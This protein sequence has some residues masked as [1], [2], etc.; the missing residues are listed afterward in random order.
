MKAPHREEIMPGVHLTFLETSKFK[1]S[2]MSAAFVRPLAAHE[3]SKNALLP[4][5]LLRGCREYPDMESL[6]AAMDELYGAGFSDIS[7]KKEESQLVGLAASVIDD[8]YAPGE[9][10]KNRTAKL[11]GKLLMDSAMDKGFF[12][13]D[14][15]Q[16][17]KANL[18]DA[19]EGQINDKRRYSLLRLVEEMCPG[20][21]YAVSSLGKAEDAEKITAE[22]LTEHYRNVL[23]SSPL[24]LYYCGNSSISE[25]KDMFLSALEGLPRKNIDPIAPVEVKSARPEPQTVFESMDVAQGKLAM[26]WRLDCQPGY[27]VTVM[28][29]NVFGGG[30]TSKLFVNVREKMSL[31]Y[32][33]SSAAAEKKRLLIASAGIEFKDFEK[34]RDAVIAQLDAIA[35]GEVSDDE[36]AHSRS[37]VLS[38]LKSME[39]SQARLE[40]FYSGQ[41]VSGDLRTP[42]EKAAEVA[43]VTKE[44]IVEAARCARLDTVYF[45]RGVQ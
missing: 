23:A 41:I 11:M 4:A 24:Q 33:V 25:V 40:G 39:D 16:G 19:I 8:R 44:Q 31:C 35:R 2:L 22:S 13:G 15:V 9:E 45:L 42:A 12:R 14:Y 20:E 17:E 18:L 36:L 30:M 6:S 5:V 3:A 43:A 10:L 28:L 26:G 37:A 7:A 21:R 27:G 38:A 32:H 1:T 34:T 29:N